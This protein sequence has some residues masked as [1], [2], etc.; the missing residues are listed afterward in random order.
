M[1]KYDGI[2]YETLKASYPDCPHD[3]DILAAHYET[4][5]Y[6]GSLWVLYRV[7]GGYEIMTD[8]HCSCYGLNGGGGN[9]FGTDRP[10]TVGEL[11]ARMNTDIHYNK[12]LFD[13]VVAYL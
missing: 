8:S 12:E 5:P 1:D 10:L 2:D 9:A 4:P 11:K 6:E 7:E 13:K 3:S